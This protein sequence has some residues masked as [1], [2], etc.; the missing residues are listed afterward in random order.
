MMSLLGEIGIQREETDPSVAAVCAPFCILL[1]A[2]FIL[3]TEFIV[4]P[5]LPRRRDDRLWLPF[6]RNPSAF[7]CLQ[8]LNTK[9]RYIDHLKR[10]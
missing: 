1:P 9:L 5:S 4:P 10:Q 7:C 8:D 2:Y 3:H 6:L